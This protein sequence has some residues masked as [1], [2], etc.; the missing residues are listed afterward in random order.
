MPDI[1]ATLPLSAIRIFEAAARLKSFTR[2]AD[3]LGVSQA[4]VSWQVKALEQRLDQPLFTRLPR[5]VAL[6]PAGE[7]LSRAATEAL[8]VL[9]TAVSDLIDTG[10]GVLSVT[11]VQ[12]IGGHWLA[13]RLGGF[14]IAHPRIAVRLDAS[15][16]VVDLQ[17]EPFDLALR[18][19]SGDWPGMEAHFLIPS[20]QTVLCTP[21]FLARAGGFAAPSD[22]LATPRIGAPEFWAAWFEAAGV[23]AA[24]DHAPPRLSADAQALEVASALAGQGA[25]L[26]S[27]IFFAQEIAQ[28][29]L[30][31]PFDITA[32][33]GGGYWLVYPTERR[34]VRKI[35]AFRDW[36][37]AQAASDPLVARHR[38]T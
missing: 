16:R 9:R 20:A 25:A 36:I 34:R 6:T 38:R 12:S 33:Y 1:L 37:L 5:E 29:R 8:G 11:T 7:R 15:S 32:Y 27:P 10:E 4:A 30:V 26:G 19:G 22:L 24:G 17:R 28:G 23:D 35:V 13:P 14:Q 3:E 2:A 31:A 18:A 21:D